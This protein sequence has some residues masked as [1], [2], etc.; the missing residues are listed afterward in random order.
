MKSPHEADGISPLKTLSTDEYIRRMNPRTGQ[1]RHY[2]I[3]VLAIA[4]YIALFFAVGPT[5]HAFKTARETVVWELTSPSKQDQGYLS[6]QLGFNELPEDLRSA[7]APRDSALRNGHVVPKEFAGTIVTVWALRR[8]HDLIP[9]LLP[10]FSAGLSSLLLMNLTKEIFEDAPSQLLGTVW[11]SFPALSINSL[12]GPNSDMLALCAFLGS[13]IAFVRYRSGASRTSA[14]YWGLLTAAAS[15]LRYPYFLIAAPFFI[16]LLRHR[17]R[18]I[19]SILFALGPLLL[20]GVAFLTF[21]AYVYGDP[22]TTGYEQARDLERELVRF[23]DRPLS[24]PSVRAAAVNI[25]THFL[26]I[27]LLFVPLLAGFSLAVRAG[28]RESSEKGYLIWPLVM[29]VVLIMAIHIPRTLWGT[30]E[31][32]LD[33]SLVRYLLPAFALTLPFWVMAFPKMLSWDEFKI[34]IAVVCIAFAAVSFLMPGG[35]RES[36]QEIDSLEKIR[37]FVTHETPPKAI[38]IT[39]LLDKAIFPSRQTLT[40]TYLTGDVGQPRGPFN[41]WDYV[42]T[43]RNFGRATTAMTGSDIPVYVLKEFS[44]ETWLRYAEELRRQGLKTQYV[45]HPNGVPEVKVYE[46]VG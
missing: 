16:A 8:L 32:T 12:G 39:R 37:A 18:N 11:I 5:K 23:T 26:G 36:A 24:D 42:P 25:A 38:V 21:N 14:F 19:V 40:L 44:D 46:I 10:A 2:L 43:A 17:P 30:Y 31:P 6:H 15:L 4:C 33:A 35:I 28:L 7:L 22:L 1:F 27:P 20:A 41:L 9:L 13:V 45:G 29:S 34:A 3:P